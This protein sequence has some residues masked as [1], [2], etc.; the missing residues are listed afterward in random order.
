MLNGLFFKI[1]SKLEFFIKIMNLLPTVFE[2][3]SIN[4]SSIFELFELKKEIV[5]LENTFR[6]QKYSNLRK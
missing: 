5:N 4:S 6:S 1:I 3:R 2:K